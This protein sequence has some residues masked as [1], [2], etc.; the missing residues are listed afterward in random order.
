MFNG[1]D[2]ENVTIMTPKEPMAMVF[3]VI[4]G[5]VFT[6]VGKYW[7]N[8]EVS[9]FVSHRHLYQLGNFVKEPTHTDTIPNNIK[10]LYKLTLDLG[11]WIFSKKGHQNGYAI[12]D[13]DLHS[14]GGSFK[15]GEKFNHLKI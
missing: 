1:S 2:C 6:K 5:N 12:Q 10:L 9:D 13:K 4:D 11:N 14:Q 8:I 15:L 7:L 3:F